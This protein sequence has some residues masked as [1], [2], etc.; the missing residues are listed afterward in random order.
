ML[1]SCGSG[2]RHHRCRLKANRCLT[3]TVR[4]TDETSR[5]CCWLLCVCA[6]STVLCL[7][8]IVMLTYDPSSFFYLCILSADLWVI[9]PSI[10]LGVML[11]IYGRSQQ[12]NCILCLQVATLRIL[13]YGF[14]PSQ[15]NSNTWI[16]CLNIKG[17]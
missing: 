8:I 11:S 1:R 16:A 4:K 13:E 15:G 2:A 14:I 9:S 17:F 10:R 5:S 3:S 12:I 6:A 7:H